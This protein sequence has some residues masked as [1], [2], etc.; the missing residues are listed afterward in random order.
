MFFVPCPE[1]DTDH[2]TSTDCADA[3]TSDGSLPTYPIDGDGSLCSVP[4]TVRVTVW[5][6]WNADV[7]GGYCPPEHPL[8]VHS[9][10]MKVVV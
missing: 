7:Y 6:T 4:M 8:G 10:P 2:D 9:D 1:T 3:G 5:V